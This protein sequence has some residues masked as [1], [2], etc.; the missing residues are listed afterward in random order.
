MTIVLKR[1]SRL[2][3][4]DGSQAAL[5]MFV[6]DPDPAGS[7]SLQWPAAPYQ[8]MALVARATF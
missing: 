5:G 3:Q 4:L 6:S 7:K 2:R 8:G 1:G